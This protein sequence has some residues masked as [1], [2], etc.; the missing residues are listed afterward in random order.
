M[1]VIVAEDDLLTRAGLVSVLT[2][3]GCDV[4]SV[5]SDSATAVRVP[6]H[7][8]PD[9]AVLDIRM[10]PTHAPEG[11]EAAAQIQHRLPGTAILVLSQYGEAD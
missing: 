6:E 4:V 11:L 2:E 7:H 9:V 3:A 1:R 10:P 5:A 8:H